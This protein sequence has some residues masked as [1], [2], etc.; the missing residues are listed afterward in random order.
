MG[1]KTM[2]IT[3]GCLCGAVRYEAD[4]PFVV[5]DGGYC[6][7]RMCQKAYGNG[8]G[9]F[10]AIRKD[11]FRF[12]RGEP[13][14]YKS[15]N[16]AERGFCANC[17]SP[18]IFRYFDAE[19]VGILIGSLDHPGDAQDAVKGGHSGIESEIPWLTVHDDLPRM[20]TEDEPLFVAAKAAVKQRD[21]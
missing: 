16:I 4:G 17:G 14:F 9:V 3:G 7:C 8:F 21:E 11:A 19:A 13:K 1:D 10:A 5:D 6:H 18:L 20:R 12:T 2:P 15:S